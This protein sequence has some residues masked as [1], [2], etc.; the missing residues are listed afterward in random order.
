MP[1]LH[2]LL[3]LKALI[4]CSRYYVACIIILFQGTI[5]QAVMVHQ[6]TSSPSHEAIMDVQQRTPPLTPI[7]SK[8]GTGMFYVQVQPRHT[9]HTKRFRIFH[10]LQAHR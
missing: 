4:I 1:F 9:I 7:E 2:T 5:S 3:E 10:N 6:S 8:S